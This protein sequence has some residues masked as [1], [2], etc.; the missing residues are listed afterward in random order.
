MGSI[1]PDVEG[2]A[3]R[4]ENSTVTPLTRDYPEVTNVRDA[5]TKRPIEALEDLIASSAECEALQKLCTPGYT[6][7]TIFLATYAILISRLTGDEDISIGVDVDSR[8]LVL[9]QT[10][11]PAQSFSSALSAL[12]D[13]LQEAKSAS[14][15]RPSLL[16]IRGRLSAAILFRFAIFD[17]TTTSSRTFGDSIETTDLIL[18]VLSEDDRNT[19]LS[20]FY[21]QRLFTS[22]RI[23]TIL[24]QI[25]CLVVAASQNQE[26]SIGRLNVMTPTQRELLPDPMRDLG[27]SS[28]RGAIHDIFARN[29]ETN[30]GRICVVETK[31]GASPQRSFNYRQIHEASNILA[32]YLVHSGIQ[33]GEVVMVYAHRGVDLVVAVMG[34]LKAGATF[35]VIDPAYPPE[36]QNIYLEVAQP[37]ALVVIEKASKEAGELSQVVKSYITSKLQLRANVPAL[38]LKDDG[39]LL[40]GLK[41]GFDIFSDY[42][43]LKIHSPGVVVGPDSTPTLSFTSGSEGKPKGVRGRHFS[44]AYYFDWMSERFRLSKEDKFTMLSGI[45]HGTR[46]SIIENSSR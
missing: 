2:W 5:A 17:G 22:A 37:R 32:H 3:S 46:N 9:R 18:R 24:S 44:L 31:S 8:P 35:S 34:V 45:A 28:F 1:D 21:N 38:A 11:T 10:L 27:W 12:H 16:S 23:Q 14:S 4:L 30:P 42:L 29:A 7:F 43:K 20:G 19:R 40:G 36:R 6:P 33:R 25:L 39:T 26:E 13:Q 41:D 15:K